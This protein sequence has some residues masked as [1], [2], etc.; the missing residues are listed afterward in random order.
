MLTCGPLPILSPAMTHGGPPRRQGLGSH[1]AHMWAIF[2]FVPVQSIWDPRESRGEVA[3]MPT[4]G[5]FLLL[6][7]CRALGTPE[8]AGVR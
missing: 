7:P 1:Y 8:T 5:P 2:A 4:C 6:F 3:T